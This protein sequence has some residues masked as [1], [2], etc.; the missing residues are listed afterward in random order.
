[1]KAALLMDANIQLMEAKNVYD[2]ELA[3]AKNL[4]PDDERIVDMEAKVNTAMETN[5][6]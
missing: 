4:Y 6:N 1:M 5:K 3:I 2:A